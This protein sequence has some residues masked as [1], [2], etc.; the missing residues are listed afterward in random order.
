MIRDDFSAF[1]GLG[2]AAL[3][4]IRHLTVMQVAWRAETKVEDR[5]WTIIQQYCINI[6]RL[7]VALHDETLLPVVPY[8]K[9]LPSSQKLYLDL[10][11]VGQAFHVR[12]NYARARTSQETD[13]RGSFNRESTGR[14]FVH[15]RKE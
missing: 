5:V 10:I 9:L 4:S 12:P 15:R 2:A 14:S 8:L 11:G 3:A 6:A 7:Q 1:W 13:R